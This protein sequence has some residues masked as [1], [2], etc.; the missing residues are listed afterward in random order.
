MKTRASRAPSRSALELGDSA[1]DAPTLRVALFA[2]AVETGAR[3][4]VDSSVRKHT[5]EVAAR[6]ARIVYEPVSDVSPCVVRFGVVQSCGEVRYDVDETGERIK[7]QSRRNLRLVADLRHRRRGELTTSSNV[8]VETFIAGEGFIATI[9]EFAKMSRRERFRFIAEAIRQRFPRR[10]RCLAGELDDD[11]DDDDD[12]PPCNA[13]AAVAWLLRQPHALRDSLLLVEF[14]RDTIRK[15]SYPYRV[16]CA[17]DSETVARTLSEAEF[18]DVLGWRPPPVTNLDAF[19]KLLD[20][21]KV[22]LSGIDRSNINY[23]C[24]EFGSGW[25]NVSLALA[26]VLGDD[27]LCVAVDLEKDYE[28]PAAKQHPRVIVLDE[29]IWEAQFFMDVRR[30]VAG[31]VLHVHASPL[32]KFYSTLKRA[33]RKR[34]RDCDEEHLTEEELLHA[35]SMVEIEIDVAR[36]LNPLSIS[37][38]NPHNDTDGI[39]SR[40]DLLEDVYAALKFL[41][42]WC[43]SY[44][45]FNKGDIQ[46]H[47]DLYVTTNLF[48]V[49]QKA[50][51][52]RK[53]APSCP[54]AFLRR[55]QATRHKSGV[56]NQKGSREKSR[57]PLNLARDLAKF[58]AI[59]KARRIRTRC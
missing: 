54:C 29:D 20:S 36:C 30:A 33:Q 4:C 15:P 16:V 43:V 52:K 55:S 35:D 19:F 31:R 40:F 14:D 38:E 9:D 3:F 2:P 53:C 7:L 37:V 46:K 28:S 26:E 45:H 57:I 27:V 42:R 17:A 8:P 23:L 41:K 12:S 22:D 47:T 50:N 51:W 58:V 13:D 24:F 11:D 39:G 56:Q 6:C 48:N 5:A 1:V 32:C 10:L 25:A 59:L 18:A 34:R 21:M 44:C 49:M